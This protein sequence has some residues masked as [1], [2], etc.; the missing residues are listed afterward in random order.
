MRRSDVRTA[1]R[2]EASPP[3]GRAKVHRRTLFPE[4]LLWWYRWQLLVHEPLYLRGPRLQLRTL[5]PSDHTS[6]HQVRS[7]CTT[8][9]KPWKLDETRDASETRS[10]FAELCAR[11]ARWRILDRNYSFGIFLEQRFIGEVSLSSIERGAYQTCSIGYWIDQDVAGM[12]FAPEAVVVSMRFAFEALHLHRVE[13]SISPRNT[14]SRRVAEKLGFRNEGVIERYFHMAGA[15]EDG[16][17]YAMTAEEWE[18]GRETL[19]RTWL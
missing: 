2:K 15:W 6:R 14:A 3:G 13:L 5:V 1:P 12:G 19:A 18:L 4:L 9:L 8:W 10:G 11:Q 7:R 17:R 16:V